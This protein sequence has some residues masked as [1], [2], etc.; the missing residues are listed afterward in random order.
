VKEFQGKLKLEPLTI[1]ESN[2]NDVLS[3]TLVPEKLSIQ[4]E[5]NEEERTAIPLH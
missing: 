4:T 1:K 5:E 2:E 3:P